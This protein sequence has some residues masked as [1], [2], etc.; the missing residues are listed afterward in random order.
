MAN[1]LQGD[2]FNV[3]QL[4]SGDPN[5]ELPTP[6]YMGAVDQKGD[7][8]KQFQ[9]NPS[10]IGS[11]TPGYD[12]LRKDALGRGVTRYSDP[13]LRY[14]DKM[15]NRRQSELRREA[16]GG[17]EEILTRLQEGGGTISGAR[18]RIGGLTN[19]GLIR[20]LAEM[21]SKFAEQGDK[22]LADDA[23]FKRDALSQLLK[24]G[25]GNLDVQN[26]ANLGNIT[27]AISGRTGVTNF[28]RNILATLLPYIQGGFAARDIQSKEDAKAR[29]GFF[30]NLADAAVGYDPTQYQP[31]VDVGSDFNSSWKIKR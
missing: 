27:R 30:G 16:S 1:I 22:V 4:S 10:L 29:R 15:L 8:L 17:L 25:A 31:P 26:Q 13:R 14:L 6:K 23:G 7:L 3:K 18:E 11:G 19:Q 28:A 5:I 9:F 12:E 24:L 2:T 21:S 20:S